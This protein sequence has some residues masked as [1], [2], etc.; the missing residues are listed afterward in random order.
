MS[1]LKKFTPEDFTMLRSLLEKDDISEEYDN[2]WQEIS[3]KKKLME[4]DVIE[5]AVSAYIGRPVTLDDAKRVARVPLN[6]HDE[7][8]LLVDGVEIGK[9]IYKTDYSE[10]RTLLRCIFSI[11]FTPKNK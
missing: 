10:A 3:K 7:Y 4:Q 1:E 11:S 5:K 6:R 9:I 2:Y 8:A